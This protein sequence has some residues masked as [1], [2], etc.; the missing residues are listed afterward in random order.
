MCIKLQCT[1]VNLSMVV[2]H[3]PDVAGVC[4]GWDSGGLLYDTIEVINTH[5]L[6]DFCDFERGKHRS[7]VKLKSNRLQV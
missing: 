7:N 6:S 5:Y 2:I 3:L 1:K 4:V